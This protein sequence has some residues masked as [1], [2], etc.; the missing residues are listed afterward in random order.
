M[1]KGKRRCRIREAGELER[2]KKKKR[3]FLGENGEQ[4]GAQGFRLK[5][6]TSRYVCCSF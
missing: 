4:P 1:K 6:S 2:E 3:F 5:G